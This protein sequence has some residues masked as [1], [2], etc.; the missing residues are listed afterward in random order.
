MIGFKLKKLFQVICDPIFLQ[1]FLKGVAAGTEHKMVLQL[2]DLDFVVDVGANRGQ[3]ALVARKAAPDARIIS[4]EPLAE[5][6]LI[7]NRVFDHNPNVTLYPYAIGREKTHSTIHVTKDDDSSSL[8]PISKVQS[9]LFPGSI[10]KETRQVIIHPLSDFLDAA[11]IP[12]ASLLKIDV[13]GY[14]FEVLQGC[15]DLLQKFSH[16]YIECSFVKLYEGQPLAYQII[17]WLEDRNF[18]LSSIQNLYYGKNG[19]AVQGDFIFTKLVNL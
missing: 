3:F 6:N 13:Q 1:A 10:E 4:F 16:L 17:S 11:S 7:F 5:P 14:E 18:V 15:E 8:L 19:L 9:D 2:L 12:P